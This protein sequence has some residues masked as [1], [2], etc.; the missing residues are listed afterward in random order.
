MKYKNE[1]H[2]LK[3]LPQIFCTRCHRGTAI[4][5]TGSDGKATQAVG[6]SVNNCYSDTACL[7][8]L[9]TKFSNVANRNIE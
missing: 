9:T 1:F 2:T 3:D 5:A 4:S 8:S 6:M 7:D